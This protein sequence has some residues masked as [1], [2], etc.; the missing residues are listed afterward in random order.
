MHQ[1]RT[2]TLLATLIG[3][4]AA[5]SAAAI[6]L[7][8][9]TPAAAAEPIRTYLNGRE[10]TFDVPPQVENGRAL[11]PV[12][13]L[14]QPMGATVSWDDRTR[15]VAATLGDR[16]IRLRIDDRVAYVDGQPVVLDTAPRIRSG[17]TL[18]PLRFV[19][20]GL[21]AWVNWD[22]ELRAIAIDTRTPV[23]R[24]GS[25]AVLA[26]SSWPGFR[27]AEIA[28]SLVGKPYAWG[29]TTPAGFDCSG[30]TLYVARQ[31]GVELPR[32]SQDQFTV[33]TPVRVE[34]LLPGDLVFYST[35]APGPT[36]VGIYIG[37]GQFVSALNESTGVAITEMDAP[38]W[39]GRYVGARRVVSLS[40]AP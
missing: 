21:G 19:S 27:M 6:L 7:I 29:G 10:L 32:T 5:A 30:F 23:S 31:V 37:E 9:P 33:G 1:Q 13:G 39:R 20:E 38:W 28:R 35:Y 18:V 2:R 4:V 8:A 26:R 14:L 12:R 24:S 16:S 17:R 40:A 36:H 34:D 3:T 11:V 22:P 15:T 25:A